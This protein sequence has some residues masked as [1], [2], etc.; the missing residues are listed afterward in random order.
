[1]SEK[2]R[3]EKMKRK[4]KEGKKR[5]KKRKINGANKIKDKMKKNTSI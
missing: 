1:M 3:N 5:K 2:K 4:K